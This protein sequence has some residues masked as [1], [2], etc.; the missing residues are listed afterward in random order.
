MAHFLAVLRV[1]RGF[2]LAKT[3]LFSF[4]ILPDKVYSSLNMYYPYETVIK[5]KNLCYVTY[6]K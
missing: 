1:S 4:P 6:E 3:M 2:L 5:T